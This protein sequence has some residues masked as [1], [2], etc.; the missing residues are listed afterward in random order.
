MATNKVDF[1]SRNLDNQVLTAV[2]HTSDIEF[3]LLCPQSS[4]SLS[5]GF[6]AEEI[7]PSQATESIGRIML[8]EILILTIYINM[9]M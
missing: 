6:Y 7:G 9:Y 5:S 4:S 8:D 2:P 3:L 1:A